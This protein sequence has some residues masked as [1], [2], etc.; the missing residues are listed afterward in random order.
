MKAYMWIKND[1]NR[2]FGFG[3]GGAYS[4]V[5][6]KV[7]S[8]NEAFYLLI[9]DDPYYDDW[10]VEDYAKLYKQIR[11]KFNDYKKYQRKKFLHNLNIFYMLSINK[12]IDS[13]I[14]CT[15]R[16]KSYYLSSKIDKDSNILIAE[17]YVF[18]AIIHTTKYRD[19]KAPTKIA[20]KAALKLTNQIFNKEVVL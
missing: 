16:E 3:Y 5:I 9:D 4:L 15:L 14:D 12:T 18:D 1:A 6:G 17:T 10:I 20:Q 2:T 13:L 7:K 19:L 11:I 8:V